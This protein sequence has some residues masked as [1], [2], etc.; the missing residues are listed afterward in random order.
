MLS[1]GTVLAVLQVRVS[2]RWMSCSRSASLELQVTG[3]AR[4]R[5]LTGG[6]PC[7]HRMATSRRRD[8]P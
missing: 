7:T 4:Y 5:K 8:R 2:A 6:T 3:V 1:L